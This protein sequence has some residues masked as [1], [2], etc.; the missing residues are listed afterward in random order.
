MLERLTNGQI[1]IGW[2]RVVAAPGYEGERYSVVQFCHPRPWTSCRRCRA[3]ARRSGRSASPPSRPPTPWTRCSTRST[4]SKTPGGSDR[5]MQRRVRTALD[6]PQRPDPR[7][8]HPVGALRPR[9]PPRRHDV[10]DEP[11]GRDP[12]D[13]RVRRR[14]RLPGPRRR[15]AGRH[16]PAGLGARHRRRRLRAARPRRPAVGAVPTRCAGARR[17]RLAGARLRAPA[18]LRARAVRARSATPPAA[19]QP[20]RRRGPPRL[21]RRARRRPHRPGPRVT[22]M[23]SRRWTSSSRACSPSSRPDRWRSTSP[24]ARP[25]P[26]P[27]PPSS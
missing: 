7:P 18:R 1:P 6:R 4:S 9:H 21:R 13:R 2:H 11:R 14:R 5:P 10:G 3:A 8:L 22:S 24:T 12:P 17:R 23:R 26:P 20:G 15:A 27:T 25:S 16:P 19:W